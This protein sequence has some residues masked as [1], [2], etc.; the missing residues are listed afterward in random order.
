MPLSSHL[1][2]GFIRLTYE[3]TVK[4]HHQIIPIKFAVAHPTQGIEPELLT[5]NDT[6]VNFTDALNTYV[7]TALVK[8]LA[9]GV[10]VGAADIY[11]VDDETG[12][13]EFIYTANAADEGENINPT[14]PFVESV[15]V[16]K[17]F[18]GKPIKVY[19]M[20]AVFEAD[21][22]NV[23][24]VPADAR[25][26]MLDYVLSDDNI[27]YGRTNAFPLAFSTFTSKVNDVL[28]RNGGFTDV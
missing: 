21:S 15:W 10:R 9:A 14:Q 1:A 13:R 18:V 17:S 12:V 27:F 23:G 2:P 4:P 24:S 3:G 20:E 5:S 19:V 6:P 7:S 25:Q 26:D 16:F 22:R 8:V 11:W 28:R